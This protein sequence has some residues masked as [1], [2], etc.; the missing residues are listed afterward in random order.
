MVRG[1][2]LFRGDGVIDQR[3]MNPRAAAAFVPAY[4]SG[5]LAVD[6]ETG[7][8]TGSGSSRWA[9]ASLHTVPKDGAFRVNADCTGTYEYQMQV[10]ETNG[11][12][13]G[14]APLIITGNGER[15]FLLMPSLPAIYIYERVSIP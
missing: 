4:G 13:G 9:G 2:Y 11:T 5:V 14:S 8:V 7:A 12:I 3:A 10:V 1:S 6:P 15:L